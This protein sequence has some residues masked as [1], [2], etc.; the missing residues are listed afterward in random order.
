M[1]C[2]QIAGRSVE[3]QVSVCS[4]INITGWTM[5]GTPVVN[6]IL[7]LTVI[8][9]LVRRGIVLPRKPD[10]ETPSDDSLLSNQYSGGEGT[11]VWCGE[12]NVHESIG[13][14]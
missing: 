6:T 1:R 12:I 4:Q 5:L 9:E 13:R 3:L 2:V 14:Y 10:T 7:V 8:T 11:K